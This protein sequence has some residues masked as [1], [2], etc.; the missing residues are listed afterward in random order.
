MISLSRK[1]IEQLIDLPSAAK[2]I[3]RAYRSTSAGHVNLPPVGYIDFAKPFGECHIKCGH[4]RGDK[5]FVIKIATGFPDNADNNLPT[6]NGMVMVMSATTGAVQAILHDEMLLTDIRTAVGAAIASRVLARADAK[7]LLVVGAGQQAYWQIRAHKALMPNLDNFQLWGRNAERAENV[8][9]SLS[10]EC[11]I[12][13][14]EDLEQAVRQA[15]VIVTVTGAKSAIIKSEWVGNNTHITAVG[16]DA[17][18]KQ[19]LE[20]ELVGKSSLLVVDNK[21]QCA[22][23]GEVSHA[24]EAG[25]VNQSNLIELGTILDNPQLGRSIDTQISIADL[26]GLAAQDIEIAKDVLS[27]FT[28]G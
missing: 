23:H 9:Q 20:I 19:E 21:S 13:R 27:R 25:T 24:L 12:K 22:D 4:S 26:T 5:N 3:E 2:A 6:G 8:I 18:G 15:D 1:E 10:A 7:R 16:A 14:A 28:E 11:Q 17:P